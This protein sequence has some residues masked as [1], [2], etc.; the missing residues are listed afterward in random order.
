MVRAEHVAGSG[1]AG[2]AEC[3]VIVVADLRRT[4]VAP[5][6]AF[7]VSGVRRSS[8]CVVDVLEAVAVLVLIRVVT[9]MWV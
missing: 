8:G 6:G 1:D 7:D 2:V 3:V 4:A 5:W 9:C